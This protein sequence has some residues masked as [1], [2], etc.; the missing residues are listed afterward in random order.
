LVLAGEVNGT[1][2]V[3]LGFDPLSSD[4]PLRIAWPVF[5]FNSVG[6]LT[7]TDP[8]ASESDLVKVGQPYSLPM[9]NGIGAEDVQVL[10]PNGQVIE[11]LFRGNRLNLPEPN[12]AG[13][14]TVEGPTFVRQIPM[15]LLSKRESNI[16]PQSDLNI[17]KAQPTLTQAAALPG[18]RELWRELLILVL[19]LMI[20]EWLLYH[21]RE[22]L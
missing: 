15:N 21:R 11:P 2:L 9:P 16:A 18:H 12:T 13:I 17:Q 14:Y 20:A 1:R 5:L 3:Q 8:L 6:W 7:E 4:L 19:L 10:D 22:V